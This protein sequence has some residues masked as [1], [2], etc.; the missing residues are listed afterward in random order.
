M[1]VL[2]IS[3]ISNVVAGM[4]QGPLS[5]D[6]VL[7]ASREAQGDLEALVRGVIQKL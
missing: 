5:H 4:G 6:D 2:G 1:R 7:A 3:T